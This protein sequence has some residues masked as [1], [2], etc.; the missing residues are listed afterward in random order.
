MASRMQ[1]RAE[2]GGGSSGGHGENATFSGFF[3][4]LWLRVTF[5]T[6]GHFRVSRDEEPVYADRK[7]AQ[8]YQ[9]SP[10]RLPRRVV[11]TGRPT[12][13]NFSDSSLYHPY[14]L[15]LSVLTSRRSGQVDQSSFAYSLD[16]VR[17]WPYFC[18]MGNHYCKMPHPMH[19]FRRFF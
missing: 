18:D 3:S 2:C 13:V 16:S 11:R 14:H 9:N 17:R 19:E 12:R 10:F 8:F 7:A 6:D 4:P 15:R 1:A 5:A